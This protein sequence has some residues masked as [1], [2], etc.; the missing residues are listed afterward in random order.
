MRRRRGGSRTDSSSST[1]T[2]SSSNNVKS[3]PLVG[4]LR[5]SRCAAN[6]S[7]LDSEMLF[8]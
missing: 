8:F 6:A 3:Q 5:P 4:L 1:T 7:S 2:T